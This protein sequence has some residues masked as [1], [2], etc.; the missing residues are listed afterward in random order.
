MFVHQNTSNDELEL[1]GLEL[2][3]LDEGLGENTDDL[4][5]AMT[6]VKATVSCTSH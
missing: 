6:V 2:S 5:L 1:P 3:E 4:D